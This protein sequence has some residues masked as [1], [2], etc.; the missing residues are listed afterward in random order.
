[1]EAIF[2][3]EPRVRNRT[4]PRNENANAYE[5]LPM[6]S[7]EKEKMPGKYDI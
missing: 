1:M 2:V 7:D 5:I 6:K 3:C 4:T